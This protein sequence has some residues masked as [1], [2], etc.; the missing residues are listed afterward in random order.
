MVQQNTEQGDYHLNKQ[1]ELPGPSGRRIPFNMTHEEKGEIFS[2]I[3]FRKAMSH[4]INR[5]EMWE[6]VSRGLA[7]F[8]GEKSASPLQV[9]E[10]DEIWKE[11]SVYDP[12]LANELLD[13]IGLDQRNAD[14]FRLT[15]DGEPLVVIIETVADWA[16][17]ISE[18]E[19]VAEYWQAV[20]VDARL[21]T[22]DRTIFEERR[23]TN[24]QEVCCHGSTTSGGVGFPV[25]E[26]V[27][28]WI[29]VPT[30]YQAT[31]GNLWYRWYVT[32][33]EEG[34]EPPEDVRK[35]LEI[36]DEIKVTPDA[37]KQIELFK[38][39]KRLHAKNVW[40]IW[41][42]PVWLPRCSF[43]VVK[44]NMNNVPPEFPYSWDYPSPAPTQTYLYY[45][46]P[47]QEM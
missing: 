43:V 45:F 39:I 1:C 17:A 37:A 42:G 25:A 46:D 4:A 47:P 38:E 36:Y 26:I 23:E 41:T 19:M 22:F 31:W 5:E 29:E 27:R 14:G 11:L 32:N 3:D 9:D 12:D 40:N 28:P 33:G 21:K 7:E 24:E 16:D 13:G 30:M 20:G 10:A 34:E 18:L 2:N 15:P 8:D 44:N 6:L 35:A